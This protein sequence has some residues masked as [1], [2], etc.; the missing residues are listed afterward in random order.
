MTQVTASQH[1][2][3][4]LQIIPNVLAMNSERRGDTAPGLRIETSCLLEQVITPNPVDCPDRHFHRA[5]PIHTVI[6]WVLLD[7]IETLLQ[8]LAG[9][10]LLLGHAVRHTQRHKM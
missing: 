1:A 9:V 2:F 4:K 3:V 7:P 8:E 10:L 5:M 6:R